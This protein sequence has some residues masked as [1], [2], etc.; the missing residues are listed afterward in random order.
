LTP[1]EIFRRTAMG[2]GLADI[3]QVTI[4]DGPGASGR[5]IEVR[6]PSGLCADIALDR[7]GDLLRL[8]YKGAEIGWHSNTRAPCPWPDSEAEHSLGFL[9][10]FD[11]FMVTCG[12][13][14]HG[15]PT[16]TPADDFLYPLRDNNVHPLHG[17]IAAQKAEVLEK[18]IDWDTG[19]ICIKL[20]IQQASVFGE[21]LELLRTYRFSLS[22]AEITIADHVTNRGFRPVRHGILYHFNAGYP[23]LNAQS[24]L[25]GDCWPLREQLDASGAEPS[26]DH[27]EV[28]QACAAPQDG[29]IG[30]TNG[31]GC[32]LS[33]QFDPDT[34]PV[35]ALWQAFQSG[36]FAL[37]L[38][39][40]T[41]L[42]DKKQSHLV[43]GAQRDYYLTVS[44][45]GP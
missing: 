42:N 18:Q 34:L 43:A 8:S 24:S 4:T 35:T 45:S 44:V 17:R 6:T 25:T 33:I 13:D 26:E 31:A 41:D 1:T 9:R 32:T 38:E 39:P 30:L 7:G 22:A 14:H 10:G 11:G 36:T 12:L 2:R 28:V 19:V 21:N 20:R 29:H 23:F 16:E 40:Q 37:G 5:L 3:R 15:V 27:V